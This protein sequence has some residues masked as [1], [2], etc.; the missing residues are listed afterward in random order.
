MT[1]ARPRTATKQASGLQEIVFLGIFAGYLILGNLPRLIGLGD[2]SNNLLMT[3]GLLYVAAAFYAALHPRALAFVLTRFFI[4]FAIVLLSFLK[5]VATFGFELEPF[6]FAARLLAFVFS[7]AT[8][9]TALTRRFQDKLSAVLDYFILSYLGAALLAFVVFILFPDSVS[10]WRFLARY[11][12]EFRGDPHQNRLVSSYLDPNYYAAIATLPFVLGALNFRHTRKYRYALFALFITLTIVLTVSR[13]GLATWAVLTALILLQGLWRTVKRLRVR[14]EFVLVTPFVLL[15][16]VLTSPL[17]LTSVFR[18]IQRTLSLTSDPSA[19]ARLNSF[20]VGW[21]VFIERP[22]LGTGYNYLSVYTRTLLG[23]S[24][25]D[26]SVLAI[27]INFGLLASL[28]LG[29]ILAFALLTTY[30]RIHRGNHVFYNSAFYGDA[31][32][33]LCFYLL[34]IVVFTSQFNNLVFYQFWFL[35]VLALFTYLS[36]LSKLERPHANPDR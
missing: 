28:L 31:Y 33:L 29:L 7:G 20:R 4:V 21:D 27:L 32:A 2:F 10:L 14:L 1:H 19:L 30:R 12:V 6:L 25:I 24:S 3:E 17:Y 23:S 13:S 26:S 36:T 16:V 35:P 11:G 22:L 18:V 34:V 5:G 9:A 15:G 8:L